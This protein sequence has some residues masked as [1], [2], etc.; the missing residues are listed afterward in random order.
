[1]RRLE[2]MMVPAQSLRALRK[3]GSLIA[4]TLDIQSH[5]VI[6]EWSA[7]A[8]KSRRRFGIP[9]TWT[10]GTASCC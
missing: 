3:C 6:A 2:Y 5:L 4:S 1:L 8:A 10:R 9:R 7:K